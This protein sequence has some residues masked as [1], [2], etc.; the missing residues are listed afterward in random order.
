MRL[1]LCLLAGHRW[2]AMR[3]AARYQGLSDYSLSSA[4]W[5]D[6][7]ERCGTWKGIR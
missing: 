7:C 3:H 4:F 6:W 2:A 1:L 5:S